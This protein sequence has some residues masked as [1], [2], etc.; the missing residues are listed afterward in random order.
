MPKVQKVVED[1]RNA[2][3]AVYRQSH[4]PVVIK[5]AGMLEYDLERSIIRT[6]RPLKKK[7]MK[8]L[9][10]G[11]GPISTFAAKIDIAFAL[12]IITLEVHEELH[13]IRDIRNKF[14]HSKSSI[15]LD[16][17]PLISLFNKLKRPPTASGSYDQ[18]FV[19][20]VLALD[21]FLEAYLAR[22]GETE[23]LRLYRKSPEKTFD[24]SRGG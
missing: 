19:A 1:L 9:F 14:A 21:D 2:W 7:M 20:C 8:R 16:L 18:V 3:I 12:D 13:K 23:D 17:P 24:A 4:T 10:S 5:A 15:S 11:Y 6:M 22:M